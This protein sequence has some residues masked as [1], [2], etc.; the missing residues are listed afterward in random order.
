[1]LTAG[2]S[3]Q[4]SCLFTMTLSTPINIADLRILPKF[5][6]SVTPSRKRQKSVLPYIS[7]K[8]FIFW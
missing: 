2:V 5:Y 1:L 6:G 3:P 7:S 8:S 4:A